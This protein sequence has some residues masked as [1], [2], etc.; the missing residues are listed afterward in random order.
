MLKVVEKIEEA[1][2]VT[3]SGTM[4]AD[5]VFST[6]FLEIYLKSV[7][8]FRTNNINA[9]DY[10][11]KIVYDVGRGKF[12]HHKEDILKRDNGIPYAAFG[13]LWQEYGLDLLKKTNIENP[14]EVFIAIDRDFIEGIDA[15]D[16]GNFPKID[17]PYSV[18]TISDIIKNF[19]PSY[20]SAQ[21]SN[22]QFFKAC[23]MAKSILT[24]EIYA[25][26]AKIKAKKIVEDKIKKCKKRY[27][28][29][30]E[31]LPYEDVLLSMEE[32]ENIAFV[33]FPSNR[34]GYAIKTVPKSKKDQTYRV[35]VP[36]EYAGLEGAELEKKSKI[37]GLTFCHRT[38]FMMSAK[39]KTAALKV[40]KSI[41][42]EE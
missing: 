24:E 34:G 18:K 19:N 39:N 1:N 33:I 8:V 25:M 21:D 36:E 12:D 40:V 20:D 17:A 22:T 30:D 4:H 15:D 27:L 42:Q 5:D 26:E 11:D 35:D 38:R 9:D 13:L 29:L 14:E 2:C 23:S 16:N 37:K 3:H 6:A 31:Y 7:R 32:A 10:K 28:I 41:L